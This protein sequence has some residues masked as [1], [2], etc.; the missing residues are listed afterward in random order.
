MIKTF[1]L[2]TTNPYIVTLEKMFSEATKPIKWLIISHND[3][4]M[5][6][7]LSS[8][9][10]G[11]TAVILEVSQDIW[12]FDKKIL[13]EAIEWVLQH[14]EINR[15][16]IAGNSRA[17][18][19]ESRAS[20]VGLDLQ[21]TAKDTDSKLLAG[22][23]LYN[24][25]NRESQQ[26]FAAQFQRISEIPTVCSRRL[27]GELVLYGMLYRAESGCFLLYNL[28]ADTFIPLAYI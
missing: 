4:Q 5:I 24:A 19:A 23:E 20:V 8:A 28:E 15:L 1:S 26:R 7:S 3:S 2:A 6:R 13:F 17:G 27:S 22:V 16:L 9:L 10:T 14:Y 12:D 25:Q 18:G 21:M 11:E